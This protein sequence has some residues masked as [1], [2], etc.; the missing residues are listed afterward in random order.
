MSLQSSE[1]WTA[2]TRWERPDLTPRP[3]ELLSLPSGPLRRWLEMFQRG[4]SVVTL[5][6]GPLQT[7]E[8]LE[9]LRSLDIHQHLAVPL[10]REKKLLSFVGISNPRH[11][12]HNDA[13][14]R[15]VT[16]LL[17]TRMGESRLQHHLKELCRSN[18]RHILSS[19]AVGLWTIRIPSDGRPPQLVADETMYRALGAPTSLTPEECYQFWYSRINA[20]YYSYVHDAVRSMIDTRQKVQLEYTWNHPSLNEVLVQCTGIRAEDDGDGV[21]LQGYHRI[22][23]GTHCP[24]FLPELDKREL[25]E[26]NELKQ[27]IFFHTDR[28]LIAGECR[29]ENGFPQCWIDNHIVHPHFAQEFQAAFSRVCLKSD[30][31]LPEILLQS[32]GGTY[33]WFQLSLRHPGQEEVDLNTM[34]V[35]VE[36]IGAQRVQQLGSLRVQRFYHAVLTETTAHAEVDLESG[37]LLSVGGLWRDLSQDYRGHFDH[38]IRTLQGW[39]SP[40]LSQKDLTLLDDYLSRERWSSLLERSDEARRIIFRMPVDGTER[41]VELVIHLFQ[42]SMTQSVYALLYIRNCR[43][44]ESP[45]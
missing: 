13:L 33:E 8:E 31:V 17:I 16:R 24:Q 11:C 12:S 37:Q 5:G 15:L 36:P 35:S 21:C 6:A 9:L 22:L 23:S 34:V 3:P 14:A 27:T 43:C 29:H 41:R 45:D 25:F 30:L 20:G 40:Y 19:M 32:K 10:L 1:H 42:E 2:S 4:Q 38:F 39:L 7:P 28:H 18:Y 44:Q 26:Y